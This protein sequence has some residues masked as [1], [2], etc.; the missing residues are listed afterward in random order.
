[1]FKINHL[2][3]RC[4]LSFNCILANKTQLKGITINNNKKTYA[5]TEVN[6]TR[7]IRHI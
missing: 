2:Q 6:L 5:L 3:I 4:E 1:M 7:F